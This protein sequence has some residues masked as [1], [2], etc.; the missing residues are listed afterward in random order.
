MFVAAGE[1]RKTRAIPQIPGV[2]AVYI[3]EDLEAVL[4]N[5]GSDPFGRP[6]LLRRS[7]AGRSIRTCSI[8]SLPMT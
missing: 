1:H 5:G 6:F 8:I 2:I 4:V 7:H 3:S